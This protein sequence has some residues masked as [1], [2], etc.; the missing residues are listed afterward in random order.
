MLNGECQKSPW[1]LH[2]KTNNALWP[3]ISHLYCF[4]RYHWAPICLYALC[5]SAVVCM[6]SH[7]EAF[8]YSAQQLLA[9]LSLFLI[10]NLTALYEVSNQFFIEWINHI[11]FLF[12]FATWRLGK[13][14]SCVEFVPEPCRNQTKAKQT[15]SSLHITFT[16]WTQ[17]TSKMVILKPSSF[18]QVR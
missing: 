10:C 15:W 8:G 17:N 12:L 5:A 9:V 1:L 2:E 3:A 18:L 14:G 6:W 4:Y 7:H 13:M 11:S 16:F